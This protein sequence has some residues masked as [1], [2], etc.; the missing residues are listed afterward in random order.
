M[1]N[2]KEWIIFIN[3]FVSLLDQF[4]KN[5]RNNPLKEADGRPDAEVAQESWDG[6][7]SR[8]QSKIVDLFYGQYKST[9]G[10]VLILISLIIIEFL[11]LLDTSRTINRLST[12]QEKINYI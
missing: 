1:L 4:G 8:N 12:L 2:R 3:E 5:P 11:Y 7:C 10:T 9:L 6:F